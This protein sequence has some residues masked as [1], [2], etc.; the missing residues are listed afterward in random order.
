[1]RH[2]VAGRKLGRKSAQRKA[3]LRGL[4]TELIRHGKI[5]T[6]EAKAKSVQPVVEKLITL[7]KR[8]DL[9]ARRLV[10]GRLYDPAIL[11]KLFDELAQ[12]YESRHGGY[13][14]IYKLGPRKGDGAPMA[15]IELVDYHLY[16]E[17]QAV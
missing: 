4:A 5:Q 3:L 16:E 13:T 14:R 8:G 6:T 10:A 7:A 11:Q 12:I 1:M 17:S 2:R 9:H 15:F